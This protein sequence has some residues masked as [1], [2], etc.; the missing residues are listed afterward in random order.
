MF[1]F[2]FRRNVTIIHIVISYAF[3]T[4]VQNFF[5]MNLLETSSRKIIVVL[6]IVLTLLLPI[7]LF[8][9][10]S[11]AASTSPTGLIIPLFSYPT[12]GYFQTVAQLAK[13]YPNVPIEAIIN[14]GGGPGTSYSSTY[15]SA[16]QELRSAG[17]TVLGYVPT[18]Y[19]S[20]SISTVEHMVNEYL[21]WY[22]QVNGI[23]FDQMNNQPGYQ[24]YY[25]TLYWVPG[26]TSKVSGVN[27]DAITLPPDFTVVYMPEKTAPLA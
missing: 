18:D 15:A 5:K 13:E 27:P 2:F 12:A 17:V 24:S 3:N 25:T 6:C 22:P 14:P 9:M 20:Y 8:S 16:I 1:D 4:A 11:S 23:F 26:V 7:H 21:W 10:N 19:A